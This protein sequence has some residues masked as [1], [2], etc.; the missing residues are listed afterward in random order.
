MDPG[1]REGWMEI[2][3][4]E[5]LDA[6][7]AAIGQAEANA[8]ITKQM[9][10]EHPLRPNSRL[11]IPGC[12]TAQL[13]DYVQPSDLGSD[14]KLV[15]TDI[16]PSFL[17]KARKRLQRFSGIDYHMQMDDIEET[18]LTGPYDGALVVLVLQHVEWQKAIDSLV[19]LNPSKLYIV[20]QEQD[21]SQH[22]VTKSRQLS[23]AWRKYAEIANPKLVPRTELTNYMADKGYSLVE[24]Y[25][26]KVP[27][28]KTMV[29]FV[30]Q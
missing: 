13:F 27:D 19:S 6:H 9:F 29:G 21:P 23:E 2:I 14:I 22:A 3:S 30:F 16:N 24:T 18:K 4:A 15:L 17:A 28:K 10:L 12:G 26:R 20:E 1:E 5:E 25:E 7:M 8:D 11:L